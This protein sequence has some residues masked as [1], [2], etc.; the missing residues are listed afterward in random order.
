[1]NTLTET[2]KYWA[3]KP[4]KKWVVYVSKTR[5][6]SS[7]PITTDKL[8]V[9]ASSYESACRSGKD[10]SMLTGRVSVSARLAGPGDL[11]CIATMNG[12]AV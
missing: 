6:Y 2:E 10:N 4:F 9:R 8:Y 1:M 7:K 12:V 5:G 11:G 3:G